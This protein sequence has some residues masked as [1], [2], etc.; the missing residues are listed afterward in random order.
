MTNNLTQQRMAAGTLRLRFCRTR[1]L[2]TAR[3]NSH[4]KMA[5]GQRATLPGLQ[6]RRRTRRPAQQH[7]HRLTRCPTRQRACRC[8]RRPVRQ[9]ARKTA[10]TDSEQTD[11]AL[12]LTTTNT[13]YHTEPCT[14][15]EHA[16]A[17]HS[18]M[19]RNEQAGAHSAESG[20]PPGRQKTYTAVHDSVHRHT[21]PYTRVRQRTQSR[22][23]RVRHQT[24]QAGWQNL[25]DRC[26]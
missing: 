24:R 13:H 26:R 16:R 12:P 15:S 7:V 18:A 23:R 19:H 1:V 11:P 20:T 2:R 4:A 8:T 21:S 5:P 17:A 9:R 3:L 6:V 10:R 14:A 22:V 25:P